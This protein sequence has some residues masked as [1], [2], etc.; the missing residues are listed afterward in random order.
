MTS[1][2]LLRVRCWKSAAV[3][4]KETESREEEQAEKLVGLSLIAAIR[5]SRQEVEGQSILPARFGLA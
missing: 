2:E 5:R 1:T 4:L 3:P